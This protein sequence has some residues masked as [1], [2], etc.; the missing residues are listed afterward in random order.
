MVFADRAGGFGSGPTERWWA[1]SDEARWDQGT[2][3]G[4]VEEGGDGCE[5]ESVVL[6]SSFW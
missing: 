1:E 4:E 5:Y 6:W 3:R 2:A